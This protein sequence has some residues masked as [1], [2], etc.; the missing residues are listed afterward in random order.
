MKLRNS[1]G[2]LLSGRVPRQA[3]FFPRQCLIFHLRDVRHRR[4]LHSKPCQIPLQMAKPHLE[5]DAPPAGM[6][7]SPLHPLTPAGPSPRWTRLSIHRVWCGFAG[8]VAWRDSEMLEVN[9][10]HPTTAPRCCRASLKEMSSSWEQRH[11]RSTSLSLS[12]NLKQKAL[13]GCRQALPLLP[14]FS[15][16][17]S[18]LYNFVLRSS[19]H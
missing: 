17:G 10:N 14:R 7:K 8:S 12:T 4:T 13:F 18:S 19:M 5:T 15:L 16:D 2:N 1:R 9:G 3:D 6:E 11:I